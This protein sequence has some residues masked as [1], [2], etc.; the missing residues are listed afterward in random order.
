M[1][2][3]SEIC[4]QGKDV[5]RDPLRSSAFHVVFG[6]DQLF[7]SFYN[8]LMWS[9]FLLQSGLRPNAAPYEAVS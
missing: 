1:D 5:I 7:S 2:A 3:M 4:I 6:S 9:P 8:V